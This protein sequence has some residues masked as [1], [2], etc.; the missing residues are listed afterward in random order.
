MLCEE[1]RA[2]FDFILEISYPESFLVCIDYH[3][4]ITQVVHLLLAVGYATLMD[5]IVCW[6]NLCVDVVAWNHDK[7]KALI[8]CIVRLVS[9]DLQFVAHFIPIEAKQVSTTIS[10]LLEK[11]LRRLT[12]RMKQIEVLW[13]ALPV[14][15]YRFTLDS[16]RL[17]V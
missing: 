8:G 14:R 5:S 12:R 15:N 16:V 17:G 3:L 10:I 1:S 13:T 2:P 4:K 6:A 7:L 11:A 9:P